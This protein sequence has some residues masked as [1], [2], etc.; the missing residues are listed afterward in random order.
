MRRSVLV[1]YLGKDVSNLDQGYAKAYEQKAL[2]ARRL[3]GQHKVPSIQCGWPQRE[4]C[5]AS[6]CDFQKTKR[7]AAVL[8]VLQ[9]ASRGQTI[10]NKEV[11]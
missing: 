9:P 8:R 7:D 1:S 3:S 10:R 6:L 4:R 5:P 2:L 11:R